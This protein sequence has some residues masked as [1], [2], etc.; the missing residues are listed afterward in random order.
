MKK[1]LLFVLFVGCV[2]ASC[3]VGMSLSGV[4]DGLTQPGVR[5]LHLDGT[6][7]DAARM[8]EKLQNARGDSNT[9][10]VVLRIESPGGAVGASQEIYAAVRELDS[11]KPVVASIGNV[12]ASGGFYAAMGARRVWALPGSITGSI[13]VIMH[14]A[15]FH[16]ALDKIGI[17]S[18]TVKSGEMKDAGAPW[19]P[20]NDREKAVF[21]SM[22]SDAYAQFREVVASRRNLDSA[23]LDTLA[24]GRVLTGRQAWKAGL[25][26]TTGTLVEAVAEARRLAKLDVKAPVEDEVPREPLWKKLLDPEAEGLA[27]YLPLGRSRI[28][29]SLP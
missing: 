22:I 5:I 4:E 2:L 1:F 27:R 3:R 10:A 8:V 13:G 29:F 12:G 20:M 7:A 21:Q 28:E 23:A 18:E 24:D 14:F 17:R 6:I 9:K 25:V 11:I 19:R 16:E 15:D 26:D